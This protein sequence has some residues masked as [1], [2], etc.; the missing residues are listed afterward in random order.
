[1]RVAHPLGISLEVFR[2]GSNLIRNFG[3]GGMDRA[4]CDHQFFDLS[5]VQQAFLVGLDPG[6]LA[7]VVIRIEFASQL[8]EVLAG[9]IEVDDLD[10]TGKM[11][12][13]QI[14]D[15]V[16]SENWICM[17]MRYFATTAAVA[18]MG[19]EYAESA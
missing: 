16:W 7:D 4:D 12:H 13:G 18:I 5:L 1:M 15:S 2:F 6:F 19:F 14:P 17:K 11:D 8:P 10:R 3:V 9:V